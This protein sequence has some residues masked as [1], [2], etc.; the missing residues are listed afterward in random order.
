MEGE[1]E[2]GHYIKQTSNLTIMQLKC[3]S[4]GVYPVNESTS[5]SVIKVSSMNSSILLGS[6]GKERVVSILLIR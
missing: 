2:G 1:R 4:A 6:V 5:I 3:W